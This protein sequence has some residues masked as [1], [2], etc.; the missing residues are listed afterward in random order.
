LVSTLANPIPCTNP[1]K[2]TTPILE[3]FNFGEKIFSNATYIIDMAIIGSTTTG[4][5]LITLYMAN[6]SVIE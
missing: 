3:L 6:P 4:G 2:K 5:T 1:N